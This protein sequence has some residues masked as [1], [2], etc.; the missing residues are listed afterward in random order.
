MGAAPVLVLAP[1]SIYAPHYITTVVPK[2][3]NATRYM[4]MSMCYT[5]SPPVIY[6]KYRR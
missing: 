1:C 2:Y 5:D 4:Y 3:N 6:K